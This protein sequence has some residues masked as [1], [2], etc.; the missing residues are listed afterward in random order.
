MQSAGKYIILFGILAI[1]VGI[2]IHFWGN[3]LN[4]IGKL[5]GDIRI[6]NK[7]FQFYF[8]VTTLILLSLILTAVVHLIRKFF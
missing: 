8:P 3:N 5:P 6:Q 4:W 7:N 1:I 2:I